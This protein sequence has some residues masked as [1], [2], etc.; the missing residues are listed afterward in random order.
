MKSRTTSLTLKILISIYG[1]LYA[2]SFII[3]MFSNFSNIP[4]AEVY[5]VP[6]SFLIFVAGAVYTWIN[7]KIGG[8]ILL[9]WHFI[10][11]CL[12]MFLW[13][14]AE[15]KLIMIFP[16]LVAAVFLLLKWYK[17]YGH[18]YLD[19][20]QKWEFVLRIFLLNYAAIYLV[21]VASEIGEKVLGIAWG[22]DTAATGNW[23]YS[24]LETIILCSEFFLFI[25][26]CLVTIKSK[27]VG[28]L[29]LLVWYIILVVASE[30]FFAIGNSEPWNVFAIPIFA[31]GLL[32][33]ILHF[34]QNKK[35]I[36]L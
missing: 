17:H 3:P 27:L 22:G 1:I 30:R 14:E 7:E 33:I 5:T 29:L 9:A 8:I 11:W 19:N 6:F 24:L 34:R 21:I 10:V 15:I 23:N 16:M 35:F 2:L 12:S 18:I 31:E 20:T 13:S 25:M 26:A 28:G 32:Y 4:A 36:L